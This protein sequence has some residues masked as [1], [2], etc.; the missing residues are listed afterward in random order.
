M[1]RGEVQR[2]FPA[3]GSGVLACDVRDLPKPPGDAGHRLSVKESTDA[4][5]EARSRPVLL[6]CDL[7]GCAETQRPCRQ[8][9]R[10]LDHVARLARYFRSIGSSHPQVLRD[11]RDSPLDKANVWRRGTELGIGDQLGIDELNGSTACLDRAGAGGDDVLDPLHVRPIGQK[12]E[13]ILASPEDVD[14]RSV[15]TPGVASSVREDGEARK[16]LRDRPRD[17]IDVAIHNLP[18]TPHPSP[19]GRRGVVSAHVVR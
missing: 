5:A 6:A 4:L 7:P 1:N 2:H 11:T 16:V 13:V 3:Q 18:E 17:R 19:R 8:A 10:L 14:R 12:E 15:G 9:G